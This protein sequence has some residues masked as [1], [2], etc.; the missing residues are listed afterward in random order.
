MAVRSGLDRPYNRYRY[1]L[2]TH[3]PQLR[4]IVTLVDLG[5]PLRRIAQLRDGGGSLAE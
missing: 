1:Y 2:A 3:I 4:Q 5:I